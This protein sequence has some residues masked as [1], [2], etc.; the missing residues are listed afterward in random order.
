MDLTRNFFVLCTN[1]KVYIIIHNWVEPNMNIHADL[2]SRAKGLKFCLN[3]YLQTYY[4]DVSSK[5][6]GK[7]AHL[8]R[9]TSAFIAR[10]CKLCDMYPNLMYWFIIIL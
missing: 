5:C 3:P 2:S 10:Q 1:M 4:M 9:L 8:Y 6:S 7:S